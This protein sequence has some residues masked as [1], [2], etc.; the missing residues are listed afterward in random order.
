M[1]PLTRPMKRDTR[2][3]CQRKK[4]GFIIDTAGVKYDLE[5]IVETN[6]NYRAICLTEWNTLFRR[7]HRN[8][9]AILGIA[10]L[11]AVHSAFLYL[12]AGHRISHRVTIISDGLA[13]IGQNNLNYRIPLVDSSDEFGEIARNINAMSQAMENNIEKLYIYQLRQRTAELGE[14]QSKFDPHFLYNTLEVIRANIQEKGDSKSADMIMLLSR[15][16]RNSISGRPF[17]TIREE[18]TA[19]SLYLE[20]FPAALPG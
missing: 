15:I 13:Q 18:I 16:F 10:T 17:V 5:F 12:Y 4:N 2:N 19:C 14:L 11:F 6:R 7:S 1:T 20:L 8:T 9:G 3:L